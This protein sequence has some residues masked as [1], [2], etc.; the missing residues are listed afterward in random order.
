MNRV[1]LSKLAVLFAAVALLAASC[2][3]DASSAAVA[4]GAIEGQLTIIDAWARQP[5][6]GQTTAAVYAV[7][8][9]STDTDRQIVAVTTPLTDRAELHETVIDENGVASMEQRNDGFL[10]SSGETMVFEPGGA[11]V[12][13]RDIEPDAFGDT[14]D[15]VFEFDDGET[16]AATA[17]VRSGLADNAMDA[18]DHDAMDDDTNHNDHENATGHDDHDDDDHDDG[19][20][21]DIDVA[22]LHHVDEELAAGNLD[23]DAQRLIVADYITE[24][25]ALEPADDSQ[26][27]ELL[28][29]LGDLDAALEQADLTTASELATAAHELAHGLVPHS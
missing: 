8:S 23:V 13:L 11:H 14:V 26:I 27:A 6:A 5:V 4:E 7:V 20:T 17:E 1:F 24:I 12:M 16:L 15:V 19:E 10:V 22:L 18:M 9:N 28:T 29:L 2:G 21:L 25:E 3:S